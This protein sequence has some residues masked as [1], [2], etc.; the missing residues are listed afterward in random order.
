VN[1]VSKIDIS[2]LIMLDNL[3]IAI[4]V[5]GSLGPTKEISIKNIR[6]RNVRKIEV[7]SNRP[8]P[9]IS[10][11]NIT[12]DLTQGITV[13]N[14]QNVDIQRVY[15]NNECVGICRGILADSV[16]NLTIKSTRISSGEE[17]IRITNCKGI[18]ENTDVSN[19]KLKTP[20]TYGGGIYLTNKSEI[21]FKNVDLIGNQG[22]HGGAFYCGEA[23]LNI[24]GGKIH[25]N[26]GTMTAG[27][28]QCDPA[29]CAFFVIGTDFKNNTQT[30]T[31]SV[32]RGVPQ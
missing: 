6:G 14:A 10:L 19:V 22:T 1:A 20:N 21:R 7:V 16:S 28:G 15:L 8:I 2:D 12:L 25:H 23:T 4:S 17:G 13:K 32:C 26:I 9:S 24:V 27:A 5:I 11:N 29:R 18:I 31:P 30:Q 3:G